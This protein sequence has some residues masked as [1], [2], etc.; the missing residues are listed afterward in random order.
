MRPV[1]PVPTRAPGNAR[2]WPHRARLCAPLVGVLFAGTAQ[3]AAAQ[4][5]AFYDTLLAF[6]FVLAVAKL[7]EELFE[8]LGQPTVLGELLV[9]MILSGLA[10]VEVSFASSLRDNAGLQA[11]AE[12]GVILL[13]FEVGLHSRL[14][15]LLEV[16]WSAALAAT[17]GVLAPVG[18]GWLVSQWFLPAEP[19]YVHLFAGATLAAT[20]V[21]ITARVLQEL[22]SL[23]TKEARVILGAA[24]VDDIL[25]L[26]LLAVLTGLVGSLAQGGAARIDAGVVGGII[27][28]AALFLLGAIALG[29]L[30]HIRTARLGLHLRVPGVPIAIAVGFCLALAALA[31]KAGLAPIVGAFAAGLILE[32]GDYEAYEK[33]GELPIERLIRPLSSLLTPVFFVM[34]GL[35][36]DLRAFA[37]REALGYALAITL[38]A[39]VSKLACALGVVQK[40][41]N[42]M[43]VGVGMIPRGEVGLIFTGIGARLAVGGEPVF[44]PATVSAMIV[45]V[46]VTT[47]AAP[48]ALKALLKSPASIERP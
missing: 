35:Q 28:K 16:G 43:V 41:V 26:V 45:M 40:G 22:K 27:G 9:G 13:L 42:R 20:S 18:L 6:V 5:T 29:R 32:P 23:D 25:G 2:R 10:L 3:A 19:W 11:I 34:M 31:G 47:L 14:H 37:S 4:G 17:L 36:V 30:L 7:G 48:P 21:G 46:I 15:E 33:R 44:E 38:V 24:V 39:L 1:S 8:R 12:V